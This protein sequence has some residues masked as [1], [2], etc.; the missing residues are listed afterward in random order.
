MS[1][2]ETYYHDPTTYMVPQYVLASAIPW[3]NR[4]THN[5]SYVLQAAVHIVKPAQSRTIDGSHLR[6]GIFWMIIP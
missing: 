4:T 1:G 3:K 6:G 2:T 5:C